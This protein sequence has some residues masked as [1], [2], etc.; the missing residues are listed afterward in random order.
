MIAPTARRIARQLKNRWGRSR[1]RRGAE[2]KS[3][4][5]LERLREEVEQRKQR[6]ADLERRLA[7]QEKEYEK[8]I[9]EYEKKIGENEKKI[10]ED[11]KK[12]ADLER[13]L[14]LR[15]RNS[16][17]SSKP[18]SSDGLAGE[19]RLRGC[20]QKRRK[21][22]R[23]AGGQKGHP[24]HWR[25]LVPLELVNRVVQLFPDHCGRCQR[26]LPSD[27][28]TRV[29]TGEP[30]RHQVTELPEI[31]A[32]I[33]EFQMCNVVCDDCQAIT[34][35]PL[36][37]EVRGHFGPRLTAAM[38]YMTVLCHI[39]RRGMQ[40]L[41]EQVLG[42]PLS[43]GTT[44]NAWEEASAAVAEP[45]QEL[46][47]A[48]PRQPVLNGDETSSR[49]KIDKRWLWVFVA[50]SFVFYTIELSRG[51]KVLVRLLGKQFAGVLCNDR[52][53][54]YLKYVKL[55]AQVLM[56]FCW[57]HFKR[58]LLGAQ[59]VAR[60]RGGKR[61]CREALACERRLFRLWHR[62]CAGVSV[63]GSPPLTRE[64]LIKKSMPLQKQL[65][66]LGRHS[67]CKD[68]D[69]A[70]LA[71]A[72]SKHKDKFFTFLK[73]EGVE[74]TNNTSERALRPAVQWRK[75]TFGN[76]SREG[77]LAVA[78]LL[79]VRATCQIQKR[80]ALGYLTEAIQRYRAQKPAPSL[81]KL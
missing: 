68:R 72:L 4:D 14:A 75:I 12:I 5:E 32:D 45:Y 79:T 67:R 36:P 17:N 76:R 51:T 16:T 59:E 80:N 49:T 69:V 22:R 62:F 63:R 1:P 53:N 73:H 33:T 40:C 35:A 23:K 11:E 47:E 74:P 25:P 66:A 30:R 65:L 34:Q 3:K 9:G 81:L 10:A 6:I 58:N 55:N 43:L 57:A 77:E 8:K 24:G 52:L 2:C 60:S 15:R 19:Q 29:T 38:A 64:Q 31:K 44:Q 39:P 50:Q 27:A 26:S 13:Q 48:L 42:I 21:S 41:L 61:F 70:N 37:P 28:A 7:E 71:R 46:Q 56:Q 20:R 54:S 78:R 18:P